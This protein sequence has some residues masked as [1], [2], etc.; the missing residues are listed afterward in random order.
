TAIISSL[1]EHGRQDAVLRSRIQFFT[2]GSNLLQRFSRKGVNFAPAKAGTLLFIRNEVFLVGVGLF[3]TY[4]FS[5]LAIGIF[6]NLGMTC[7]T[8]APRDTMIYLTANATI[9]IVFAVI[10]YFVWRRSKGRAG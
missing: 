7:E 2:A 10:G 1:L 9:G 3:V 4:V 8:I 5:S 6:F